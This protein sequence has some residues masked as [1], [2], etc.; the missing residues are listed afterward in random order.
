VELETEGRDDDIWTDGMGQMAMIMGMIMIKE[1][2]VWEWR[3]T[4]IN[5]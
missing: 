4:A 5:C 1:E 3:K 2:N